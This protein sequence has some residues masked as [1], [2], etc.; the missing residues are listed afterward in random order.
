MEVRCTE[1]LAPP[2]W[3]SARPYLAAAAYKRR[4]G[5]RGFHA[6][7][8]RCVGSPSPAGYSRVFD[9]LRDCIFCTRISAKKKTWTRPRIRVGV[10]IAIGCTH[11]LY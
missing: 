9:Y 5:L 6:D 8:Y 10:A 4:V 3:R 2:N 7:S 11:F 1:R